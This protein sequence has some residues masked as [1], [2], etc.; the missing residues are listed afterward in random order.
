MY[1]YLD[2]K[3][4]LVPLTG[5]AYTELIE[6]RFYLR[7]LRANT[8][9]GL[10]QILFLPLQSSLRWLEAALIAESSEATR[11]PFNDLVN[12]LCP[13]V[14]RWEIESCYKPA[15]L[16]GRVSGLSKV[17]CDSWRLFKSTA[18]EIEVC[19]FC[20]LFFF[21][22]LLKSFK[23]GGKIEIVLRVLYALDSQGSICIGAMCRSRIGGR[24]DPRIALIPNIVPSRQLPAS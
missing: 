7:G 14:T 23:V 11:Y 15:S 18:K 12:G 8:C 1:F 16:P 2:S 24:R 22:E 13:H 9:P 4:I 10:G 19:A 3:I 20:H 6:G 5:L 17:K 21:G